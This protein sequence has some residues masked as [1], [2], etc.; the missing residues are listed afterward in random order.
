MSAIHVLLERF[1]QDHPRG[2][3]L[4]QIIWRGK[5]R[6]VLAGPFWDDLPR[7]CAPRGPGMGKGNLKFLLD[8]WARAGESVPVLLIVEVCP[9]RVVYTLGVPEGPDTQRL[10]ARYL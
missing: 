7:G 10:R 6:Y 4:K 3:A 5:P 2:L 1:F 8:E 9:R